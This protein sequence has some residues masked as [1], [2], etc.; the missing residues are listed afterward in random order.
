MDGF[1]LYYDQ[2]DEGV[3]VEDESCEE[4]CYQV[5]GLKFYYFG[6]VLFQQ[7]VKVMLKNI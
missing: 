4:Y 6:N 1:C 5:F 2:E 3:E 7:G